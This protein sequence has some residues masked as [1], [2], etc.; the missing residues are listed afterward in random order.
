MRLGLKDGFDVVFDTAGGSSVAA[1]IDAARNYGKLVLVNDPSGLELQSAYRKSLS[2]HFIM[3]LLPML[4]GVGRERH[5]L[6]LRE[7]ADLVDKGHIRPLLAK[8]RFSF[9]QANE[10]HAYF[11]SGKACGKIVLENV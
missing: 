7:I 9:A 4:T 1:A 3:M 11:E 8:R 5:G 10:A 2:I 6:I